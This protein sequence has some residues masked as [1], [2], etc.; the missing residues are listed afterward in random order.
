MLGDGLTAALILVSGEFTINGSN[1]YVFHELYKLI[2]VS[3]SIK[4]S[5]AH[6]GSAIENLRPLQI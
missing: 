4:K 6:P 5:M 1:M 2:L 3:I